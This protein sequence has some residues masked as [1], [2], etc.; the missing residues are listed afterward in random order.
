MREG[1]GGEKTVDHQWNMAEGAYARLQELLE[2]DQEKDA[3]DASFGGGGAEGP[4]DSRK[5]EML[6]G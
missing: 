1:S 4:F 6:N 2:K 3:L 5:I